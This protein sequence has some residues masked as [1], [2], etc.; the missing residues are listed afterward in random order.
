MYKK[1]KAAVEISTESKQSKHSRVKVHADYSLLVPGC[2]L[3]A[4]ARPVQVDWKKQAW[5]QALPNCQR[6]C[7]NALLWKLEFPVYL[8][9]VSSFYKEFLCLFSK[10]EKLFIYILK[11]RKEGF[12]RTLVLTIFGYVLVKSDKKMWA[13]RIFPV[14]DSSMNVWALEFGIR[15]FYKVLKDLM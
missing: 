7:A 11:K 12:Y 1:E 10:K 14:N 9:Q 5:N 8:L 4:S 15:H 6:G 3:P 2:D 13:G